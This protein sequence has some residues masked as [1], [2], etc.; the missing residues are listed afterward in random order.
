MNFFMTFAEEISHRCEIPSC[1]G[2]E[3]FISNS[4]EEMCYVRGLRQHLGTAI[5]SPETVHAGVRF[6]PQR[7]RVA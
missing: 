5:P 7:Q 1:K 6:D 4:F 2:S 3:K